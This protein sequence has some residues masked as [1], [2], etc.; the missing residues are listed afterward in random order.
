MLSS[1][2]SPLEPRVSVVLPVHNA[3]PH[4]DRAIESILG[5]TFED[6]EFVIL[7]DASTDGSSHR[8]LQWAKRD[9]RI[10]LIQSHYNL[11]PARSS[12]R[13]ARA[14][15]APIVARM[16]ADDVAFP[17]CLEEEFRVLEANPHVGLVG[18][19]C[20]T[21]DSHG[22]K[23]RD[24]E[25]WRLAR[26]SLMVPFGHSLMMYRRSIFEALGG[27]RPQC[28]YWEDEDL[29]LRFASVC[30]VMV[31]PKALTQ[32]RQWSGSSRVVAARER[33]ERALQ[34]MYSCLDRLEGGESYQRLLDSET[35]A[36]AKL[37]PR[38]FISIGLAH[39]WAGETPHLFRD[40][41]A[42]GDLRAEPRSIT[43][44]AWTALATACPALLRRL[45]RLL[46]HLRGFTASRKIKISSDAPI[47]WQTPRPIPNLQTPGAPMARMREALR[48]AA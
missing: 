6:F 29:I 48:S 24:A 43:A 27:Y 9:H 7:D 10:R 37:D 8:L 42:R 36:R 40:L 45:M 11:G 32:M 28:D 31:I 2:G 14:A 15:S 26:K 13:V 16:D 21:I 30:R 23:V 46:L 47:E 18:S 39:L 33:R 20:E 1:A 12:E 44:L 38:V 25:L 35:D 41:I 4:L 34:L 5:Q 19:L 3:L 17:T 22:N